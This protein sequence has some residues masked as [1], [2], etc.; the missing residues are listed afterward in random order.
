MLLH[1]EL[2]GHVRKLCDR[3]PGEDRDP[4]LY[5]D[6]IHRLRWG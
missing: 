2:V 1:E 6:K 5:I 3:H 4:Y